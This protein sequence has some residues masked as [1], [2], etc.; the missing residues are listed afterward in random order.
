MTVAEQNPIVHRIINLSDGS[1]G[2]EGQRAQ[3]AGLSPMAKAARLYGTF[4]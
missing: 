1:E 3:R 4:V 2:S